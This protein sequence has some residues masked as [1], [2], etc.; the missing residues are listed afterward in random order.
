MSV[1]ISFTIPNDAR[2]LRATAKFLLDL[3]DG[4]GLPGGTVIDDIRA[5]VAASEGFNPTHDELGDLTDAAATIERQIPASEGGTGPE[6]TAEDTTTTTE[7]AA[8]PP[9]EKT[10]TTTP[11]DVE[12]APSSTGD[13]IPWDHRIHSGGKDK[14][15]AKAPHSWKMKRGVAGAQVDQVEAELRAAM[16]A[17]PD[18]P[19]V[20]DTATAAG[21]FSEEAAPPPPEETTGAPP[22]ITNFLELN[23]AV[24]E[25]C[26][27][28]GDVFAAVKQVGLAAYP[29]LGAR[30]DLI[31]AVV[32]ILF[33]PVAGS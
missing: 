19:I 20:D 25:A 23:L 10:D 8:A 9:P 31:P 18:R 17:S 12:L 14:K 26:I 22:K 5:R 4:P 24:T 11:N 21:A 15:L 13:L 30:P 7:E 1:T 28:N 6:R 32:A 33:P 2:T 29:L 3:A 27:P 16:L